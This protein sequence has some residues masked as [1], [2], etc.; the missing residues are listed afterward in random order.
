MP[1]T[2]P[3][4][5]KEKEISLIYIAGEVREAGAIENILTEADIDY[6]VAH[7]SYLREMLFEGAKELPGVGFY[8]L[9]GQAEICREKLL[10]AGYKAGIVLDG[11][12]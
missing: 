2:D 11:E 10:T 3:D 12:E 6:T 1:Y 8:V 7:A 4:K 9:A 5:F